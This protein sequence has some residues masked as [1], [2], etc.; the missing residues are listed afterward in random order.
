MANISQACIKNYFQYYSR[1]RGRTQQERGGKNM[2]ISKGEGA[3]ILLAVVFLSFTAGWLFRS[4]GQTQ[5]V[6]AEPQRVLE[7][8]PLALPAPTESPE[9]PKIDINTA[10]AEELQTLPRIGEKRAADIVRDREANGPY[11]FP[12]DLVRVPGIGEDT[13]NALLDH[14]TVGGAS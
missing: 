12:E 1:A 13:V 2:K 7:T 9:T 3:V 11:R 10:T 6:R 8:A 4:G 5:S 14:I